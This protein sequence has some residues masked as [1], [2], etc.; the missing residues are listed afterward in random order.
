MDLTD[1]MHPTDQTHHE[2]GEPAVHVQWCND[3]RSIGAFCLGLVLYMVDCYVNHP[4]L[5]LA[6]TLGLCDLEE[7]SCALYN[8]DVFLCQLFLSSAR[9]QVYGVFTQE[10]RGKALEAGLSQ[11]TALLVVGCVVK[12]V[13]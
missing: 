4:G 9:H 11:P 1:Q 8:L 3:E 2:L 12:G 5:V 13:A 7:R 6:S 10:V